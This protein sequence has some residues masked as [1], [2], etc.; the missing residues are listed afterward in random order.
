MNE[1]EAKRLSLR[2]METTWA[3]YVTTVDEN[4]LPHT[5]AMDNWRSRE[6][7]PRIADV[8]KSNDDDFWILL[9]T[10]TS[11]SK[12]AHIRMNPQ[13]SVYYCEPKEFRGLALSGTAELVTDSRLK[14]EV[15]HD[16][17]VAF[18]KS[19]DDP[20]YTVLSIH[21]A[22]AEGWWENCKFRF[23]LNKRK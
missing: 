22:R 1:I 8:F 7:F 21:P 6:R 5:R 17:W 18:Y 10:N 15:W 20:D 11:S 13:V 3:V 16:Y 23:D 19:A 2:L 9:G 14:K 4:G 12:M